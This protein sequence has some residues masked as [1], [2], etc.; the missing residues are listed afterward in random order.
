MSLEFYQILTARL[1]NFLASMPKPKAL[2]KSKPEHPSKK[3]KTVDCLET[4]M[5]VAHR[6][7]KLKCKLRIHGRKEP[8]TKDKFE[9]IQESFTVL[10]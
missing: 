6:L 4:S 2:H 7:Q 1:D 3:V 9:K 10:G 8:K 5:D